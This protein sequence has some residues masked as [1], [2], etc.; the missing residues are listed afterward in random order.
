MSLHVRLPVGV[1]VELNGE[2][3]EDALWDYWRI[4]A[5]PGQRRTKLLLRLREDLALYELA[6]APTQPMPMGD[7]PNTQPADMA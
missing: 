3:L 4:D 5:E 7:F 6:T 2:A 1:A